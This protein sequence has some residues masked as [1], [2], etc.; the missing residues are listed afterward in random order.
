MIEVNCQQCGRAFQAKAY[1]VRDGN[2]KYCSKQCHD[3]SMRGKEAAKRDLGERFW[4]KVD[5]R[6]PDECWP[7][8]GYRLP[9]GYGR[10]FID[11]RPMTATRVV[12]L[13]TTGEWP[14]K[15]LIVCHH[16]DNP[17]CVNP[18]H[19]FVGTPRDNT[20]DMMAKGRHFHQA[21]ERA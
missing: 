21:K 17:P 3:A 12:L 8:M 15:G 19:L 10:F 2:A 11:G 5:K 13:L 14:Q 1:R 16:C 6:G 9:M 20:A 18:A 4:E 7:W